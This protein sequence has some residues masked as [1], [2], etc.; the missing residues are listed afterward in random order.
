MSP[1]GGR[2]TP[3]RP[4][5]LPYSRVVTIAKVA[6]FIRPASLAAA[7]VAVRDGARPVSGGTDLML[8]P[9]DHPTELVDL[10]VLPLS[11]I[12]SY[13]G[14][15]RIGS[16]T[17]LTE[18]LEDPRVAAMGDGMVGEMLLEVGSP[19]LRNRATI[20]GHLARGRLSDVIPVL[21]ALDVAITWHDGSDHRQSLAAY[22]R[23][24]RHRTPTI[25][26]AVTIPG[27]APRSSAA[28]RKFTRTAFELAALNTACRIDLTSAGTVAAARVVVGETPAVAASLTDVEVHLAGRTFD[29]VTIESAAEMAAAAV[30]ARSDERA[31]SE[32]RR[33]LTAVLVRRCLDRIGA[34]LA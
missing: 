28:F 9:P 27:P 1:R 16:T 23:E 33:H 25:I 3:S 15:V 13:A 22:Y 17:T 10:T 29:R 18:M 11:G 8:H 6:R 19:L 7:M 34:R 30:P 5:H 24:Q 20:G 32:Y 21:L 26:T 31:S 2:K 14:G 4:G 12:E